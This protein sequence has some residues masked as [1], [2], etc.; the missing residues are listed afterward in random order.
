MNEKGVVHGRF[1]ILHLKHMEY[2]LA[3]KMRCKRLYIGISHPDDLYL[4]GVEADRHGI[5]KSDNPLTYLERYEMIHDALIDF[6]VKR[7]DFEIIPFPITRPEYIQEYAP[8][9]A[10]YYLNV[11]D[12]WGDIKCEMLRNLDLEV[13]VLWRKTREERGVT[14]TDVRTAIAQGED[15]QQLVPKTVYEYIMQHGIDQRIKDYAV[16]TGGN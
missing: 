13:E 15:W 6:G 10:V 14:G 3:A 1:Q 4:G 2:I 16:F 9:D 12:E 11:Y 7:E 8:A 5:R